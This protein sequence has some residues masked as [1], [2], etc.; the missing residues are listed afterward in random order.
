MA[1]DAVRRV[2]LAGTP[3]PTD[4]FAI[5]KRLLDLNGALKPHVVA[6]F[7]H[8]NPEDGGGT[9]KFMVFE[10]YEGPP[11]IG[12]GEL[13][14]GYFLAPGAD[15]VLRVA[16]GFVELMAWDRKKNVYNFWEL[17]SRWFYRG[18]SNDIL[19]DVARINTEIPQGQFPAKPRLRCSGCHTLG[20]PI[21]KELEAPHNDWWT[22]A[23]K[24]SLGPFRLQTAN[25]LDEGAHLAG[26][27][28][29][30]AVDAADLRR[31]VVEG[32]HR[33]V[34]A[35]ESVDVA[36]W[37]LRHQLRS[38]VATMELNLVTDVDPFSDPNTT[39]VTIPS[40]FFVDGRLLGGGARPVRVDKSLYRQ[41][42]E[43]VGSRYTATSI[44]ADHAFVVPAVSEVD[45]SV[46]QSLLRRGLV[47]DEFIADVLA[48][49]FTTPV[50]STR[51]AAL[52]RFMPD[53]APDGAALRAHVVA[54]LREASQ[55]DASALELLSNLTDAKR[56]AELHRRAAQRYLESCNHAA[57][58]LDTV[59]GWLTI[60][61]Q[62][63]I[64]LVRAETAQHPEGNIK[65]EGF[66]R[67]FP[68]D[69]L[70]PKAGALRLDP[71]TCQATKAT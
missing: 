39:F 33:T 22:S 14:F 18:D 57:S 44:E 17:T 54:A 60:A 3:Q 27:V 31:Q 46:V 16:P 62:R 42:L 47:D 11:N 66:R 35:R 48:I 41:A 45:R 58:Q 34:T 56:S 25:N 30:D 15:Q 71:I 23:R 26:I 13:F 6:N 1:E 21:M 24:L 70:A 43:R 8:Q 63:R 52:I 61:S 12:P 37:T 68:T 64:E 29:R 4:I 67:L 32:I 38:L 53:D 20:T 49:D 40:E 28:F 5:R 59:I 7:G 36:G 10:T 55:S 51:R 9:V 2:I 50:F 19:S 69:T 65:E